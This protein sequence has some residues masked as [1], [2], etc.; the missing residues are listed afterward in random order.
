MPKC[1]VWQTLERLYSE[2][3]SKACTAACYFSIIAY[4]AFI[5]WRITAGVVLL[6]LLLL[7]SGAAAAAA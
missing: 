2:C 5:L 4:Q 1:E 6:L 3:H 7:V